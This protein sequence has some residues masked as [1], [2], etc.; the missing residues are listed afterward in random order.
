VHITSK[1][2]FWRNRDPA[3]KQSPYNQEKGQDVGDT[4]KNVAARFSQVVAWALKSAQ[5][6]GRQFHPF[7]FHHLRHYYAVMYLKN[8]G[9]IYTLQQHLNH[10]SITTTELYLAFLTS[11]EAMAAKHGSAQKPA[12]ND[13][14]LT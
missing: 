4:Y 11:E 12:Q 3:K 2:L 9:N 14:H 10:K 6:E 1:W 5:Q 8:G 7:T 13:G